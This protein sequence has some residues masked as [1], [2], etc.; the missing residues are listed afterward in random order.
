MPRRTARP[1][2]PFAKSAGERVTVHCEPRNLGLA[3][4]WNRCV[5]RARGQWVDILHQDDLVFPGFDQLLR[6]GGEKYPE[7]GAALCRHA[8]CD[9]ER[10]LASAVHFGNAFARIAAKLCRAS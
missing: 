5:E 7:A 1:R 8:Y 4:I 6:A 9:E 2:N 3:G 10:P